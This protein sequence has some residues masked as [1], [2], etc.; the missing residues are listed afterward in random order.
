MSLA[1]IISIMPSV[2]KRMSTGNSNLSNFSCLAKE[3]DMI[4]VIAEP[5]SARSFMKRENGSLTKASLKAAPSCGLSS[6]QPAATS[7]S[8]AASTLIVVFMRSLE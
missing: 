2:D 3:S 4:S 5:T 7:R 1:E 8:T 6:I